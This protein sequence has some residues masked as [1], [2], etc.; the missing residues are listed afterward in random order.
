[1]PTCPLCNKDDEYM[2]L[3]PDPD[4]WTDHAAKELVRA[5]KERQSHG[6][7]LAWCTCGTIWNYLVDDDDPS[8]CRTI[9]HPSR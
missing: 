6:Y 7:C 1:M 4:Q 8:N 3:V 2:M 5:E 9:W